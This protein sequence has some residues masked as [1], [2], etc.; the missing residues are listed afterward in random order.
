MED[1][2][3]AKFITTI[4]SA[5]KPGPILDRNGRAVGTHMGIHRYTVGQRR[6]IG[7]RSSVPLYV[8][9]IDARNN[10]VHVGPREAALKRAFGVGSVN[11]LAPRHASFRAGV[12]VRSTMQEMPALVEPIDDDRV[13]VEFDEPQWAPAPGQAA[14]FYD[15]DTV[16]G[17]GVIEP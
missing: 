6:G 4:E 5:E 14:V 9:R 2:D 3:Y 8:T 11:W 17:G 15:G 1:R 7:V 13:R 12:K 10:T 16:V